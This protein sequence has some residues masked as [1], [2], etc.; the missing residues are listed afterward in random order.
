MSALFFGLPVLDPLVPG[1]FY[2]GLLNTSL[3][4]AQLVSQPSVAA[5]SKKKNKHQRC[6]HDKQFVHC[7]KC[8]G[9]SLCKAHGIQRNQCISCGGTGVCEH[10]KLRW[11]CA[12]CGGAS[13]CQHG[14]RKARCKVCGGNAICIHGRVK[15]VCRECKAAKS[16]SEKQAAEN[17]AA[18]CD[19]SLTESGGTPGIVA[20]VRAACSENVLQ[21][22][23]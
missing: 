21:T 19:S 18:L 7:K 12:K 2:P 4:F 8:G 14:R 9:S 5:S 1:M 10:K 13:M 20:L 16:A 23:Q 15:Y 3:P 6:P 22:N 11:Q 17:L